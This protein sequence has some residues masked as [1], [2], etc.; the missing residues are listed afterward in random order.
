MSIASTLPLNHKLE[1]IAE[2]AKQA[3]AEAAGAAAAAE[4]AAAARV[5]RARQRRGLNKEY[6]ITAKGEAEGLTVNARP[7][8]TALKAHQ[9]M[10]ILSLMKDHGA[11]LSKADLVEALEDTNFRDGSIQSAK[12]LV[13]YWM[14]KFEHD[15]EW[16]EEA[17]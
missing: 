4:A 10:M 8:T 3:A 16:I 1:L 9:A 6:V 2:L 7:Y 15:T 13:T 12:A 5:A 17:R 14:K 11:G